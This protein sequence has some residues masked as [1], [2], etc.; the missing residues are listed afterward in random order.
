MP[1]IKTAIKVIRSKGLQYILFRSKYE[2]ERRTGMLVGK[3]PTELKP[4]TIPSLAEWREKGCGWF[5]DDREIIKVTKYKAPELKEKMEHILKGDVLFF[6][7]TW[8]PLG[9]DYDWVTNPETRY[10]YDACQHWTKI[11]DFSKE[12]GDIKFVWEKSRFSWLLTICRYDYHFDEDHSEYALGQI[13]DWINK[14]PLNCGPNYKCSQETSLRVLNWLF[15]LTFYRKSVAL[16]EERWQKIVTSIY[17]QIDHVYKNINFS[18]SHV[19][20]C[21]SFSKA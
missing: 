2:F 21:S 13:I 14:N 11:N 18:S 8:K 1:S 6:S 20:N 4:V 5:F 9:V 3:Y 12:A 7:K 10:H 15:A 17:W 19:G 16:T